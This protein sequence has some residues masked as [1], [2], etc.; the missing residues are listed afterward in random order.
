MYSVIAVY[1]SGSKILIGFAHSEMD[2]NGLIQDCIETNGEE[3]L[4]A[5]GIQFAVEL[6]S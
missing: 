5:A 1:P 2:V 6:V 3:A 4:K